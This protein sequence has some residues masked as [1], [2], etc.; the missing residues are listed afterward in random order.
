MGLLPRQAF[1][2]GNLYLGVE[3]LAALDLAVICLLRVDAGR[4]RL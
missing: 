4:D 1:F 2:Q 3:V